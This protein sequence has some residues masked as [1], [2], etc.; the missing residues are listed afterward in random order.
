MTLENIKKLAKNQ[1]DSKKLKDEKS[2][3]DIYFS[4]N[5]QD[6]Y[7]LANNKIFSFNDRGIG[8]WNLYSK[9]KSIYI[10]H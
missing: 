1:I 3:N 10:I 7:F 4:N 9:F 8:N 6:F 2:K 5:R